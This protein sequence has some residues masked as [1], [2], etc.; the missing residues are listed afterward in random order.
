M[1]GDFAGCV[2]VDCSSPALSRCRLAGGNVVA[3]KPYDR[4]KIASKNRVFAV[5][6]FSPAYCC[7]LPQ[8]IK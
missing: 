8:W 6:V 4:H 2:K 5:R 1:V 3:G 7:G